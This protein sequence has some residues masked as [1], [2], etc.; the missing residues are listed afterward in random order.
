MDEN[1]SKHVEWFQLFWKAVPALPIIHNIP[2]L[3]W[4]FLIIP[5]PEDLLPT[6]VAYYYYDFFY[7]MIFDLVVISSNISQCSND[8]PLNV[9]F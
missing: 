8:W 2:N 6:N 7:Y 9:T 5:Q 3:R 1:T 4:V